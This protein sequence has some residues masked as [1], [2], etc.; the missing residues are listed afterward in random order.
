MP[1]FHL[2]TLPLINTNNDYHIELDNIP[3]NEHES[4]TQVSIISFSNKFGSINLQGYF[5]LS[6]KNIPTLITINKL[7]FEISNKL[8]NECNYHFCKYKLEIEFNFTYDDIKL[9]KNI[10]N[11][12]RNEYN[13][14]IDYNNRKIYILLNEIKNINILNKIKGNIEEEEDINNNYINLMEQRRKIKNIDDDKIIKF[15][16][17]KIDMNNKNINNQEIID[18]ID[19]SLNNIEMEDISKLENPFITH[20]SAKTEENKFNTISEENANLG[21]IF[22]NRNYIKSKDINNINNLLY[23]NKNINIKENYLNTILNPKIKS[24]VNKL[25]SNGAL[26]MNNNIKTNIL[27]SININGLYCILNNTNDKYG[28]NNYKFII[29][30]LLLNNDIRID[31]NNPNE[32]FDYKKIIFYNY[33]NILDNV[34]KNKKNNNSNNLNIND[35][36]YII[37]SYINQIQNKIDEIEKKNNNKNIID[38]NNNKSFSILMKYQK[39]ISTLKLFCILF[40]NCF[41]YKPENEY[42]ND[43]NLFTDS[44]S[45]KVMSYRKRLLIEWCIDEQKNNIE[46]NISKINLNDNQNIN[47]VKSNYEKMYSFGQIRKNVDN[48]NDN[49][50]NKGV[51]LFMRAKMCNNNEKILKNNMY[52]FTGYNLLYGENN[53]KFRDIFVDKYN[54]DWLS[55]LIQSLMYEEKRDQYIVYSIE[56]LTKNINSMN[57]NAKPIIYASNNMN[58]YDI[59]FLLLKLYEKYIKGEINEQ[60]K[61]LKMLSYS[62]TITNN[63]SSD[64]F[65]Q[66]IICS[67]LLKILPIIFPKDDQI[68]QEIIDKSFIKKITYN[69]LIQSI[70]ELLINNGNVNC[71]NKDNISKT[72]NYFE[73]IKLILLSF[74][75]K[76]TKNKLIDDI[77]SKIN[78]SLDD[79]LNNI[80]ENNPLLL[81]LSE[82]QRYS[83]LGYINNSLCLWKDA[84]NFF[85]SA[86][87]YKSALDACINYAVEHIKKNNE[88]SD[89][90]EIFLRLNEIKK[91]APSL[92]VDIYQILFLFISY[93]S[94][95]KKLSFGINDIT[96]LLKEFSSEDKYF[97]CDLIDNDVRGVIIDLLYTLLIEINNKSIATGNT[98]LISEKYVKMNTELNMM[99]NSFWDN[100]KFK[101]NIFSHK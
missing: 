63:N 38:N 15:Q 70:E 32:K 2:Y 35:Y 46:K 3:Y 45:D 4:Y 88:N 83:F 101:N 31:N 42:I 84:Y 72:E 9:L 29:K 54:N 67:T 50:N 28:Y 33:I 87:E 74:L 36:T 97:C 91:N 86:K 34:V 7:S 40:L 11:Y 25:V 98:E 13:C 6:N 57:N 17:D 94:D 27:N 44:F 19:D 60:I 55:F 69:L 80:E 96:N 76:K 92:F 75:N 26:F 62:C 78:I 1:K 37:L 59:N 99:Q 51:S 48:D 79:S 100:V 58:V 49:R 21:L 18:N 64:H 12:L 41:M 43:P 39:L 77:I 66:Y 71:N 95:K 56:L 85:I 8:L 73:V 90:K 5:D 52:Y 81:L 89:F 14:S 23:D 16:F 30:E 93:M 61:Y 22:N 82:K 53:R 68:N 24:Q 47:N 10:E 20:I 65:I